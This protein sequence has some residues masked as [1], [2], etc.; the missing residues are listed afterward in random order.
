M[1][2]LR[3]T[4]LWN[5]ISNDWTT[6]YNLMHGGSPFQSPEIMKICW[7][8]FWPYYIA[9]KELPHFI[10]VYDNENPVFGIA[11]TKKINSNEATIWGKETGYNICSPI[12]TDI[13]YI[14][15]S[16]DLIIKSYGS[17]RM[18]KIHPSNPLIN[19]LNISNFVNYEAVSIDISKSYDIYFSNLTKS[20]RQNLR[21]AYNRTK[22]DEMQIKLCVLDSN[23]YN[24][25]LNS[26][27][28]LSES[29]HAQRYGH[30]KTFIGVLFRKYLNYA[31]IIYKKTNKYSLSFMLKINDEIAGVM[32]GLISQ[33]IYIV[34]RLAINDKFKRYSPGIILLNETIKWL[35]N[36]RSIINLDLSFG[37]EPYKFSMGGTKYNCYN[38]TIKEHDLHSL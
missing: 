14:K 9:R 34:P 28:N 36:N 11:L 8:N 23:G 24:K 20:S 22:T 27:I 25:N 7:I 6:I 29:R 2:S 4:I 10:I 35:Q 37:L 26:I 3:K 1:L 32:S 12:W 38:F 21:T 15:P 31:T 18:Q 19:E 33:D 30:N 5:N 16:F 17:I 13:K